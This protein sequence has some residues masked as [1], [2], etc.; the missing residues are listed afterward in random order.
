MS[1]EMADPARTRAEPR[2]ST[3]Y[4]RSST[5]HPQAAAPLG[6]QSSNTPA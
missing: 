1:G 2:T 5:S 6:T 3:P 4:G